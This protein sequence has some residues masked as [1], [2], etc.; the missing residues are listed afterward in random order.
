MVNFAETLDT[1]KASTSFRKGA[2]SVK[3]YES[4]QKNKDFLMEAANKTHEL[5]TFMETQYLPVEKSELENVPFILER[6]ITTYMKAEHFHTIY[7][8]EQTTGKHYSFRIGGNPMRSMAIQYIMNFMDDKT[9][10]MREKTFKNQNNELIVF[11]ELDS[12]S[13]EKPLISL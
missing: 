9:C 4:G 2:D 5:Q 8:K 3:K 6:C 10:T 1:K 11:Y 13:K 7:I 12:L